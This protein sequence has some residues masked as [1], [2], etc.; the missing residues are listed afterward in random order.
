MTS[1]VAPSNEL[2]DLMC[3][4]AEDR[5]S[6]EG[7]ERLDELLCADPRNCQHYI[8]FMATITRLSWIGD[9]SI[10]DAAKPTDEGQSQASLTQQA[11]DC[12][13][14]T[15][16]SQSSAVES[17]SERSDVPPF[18]LTDTIHGA[19]GYSSGWPVAYGVATAICGLGLL[20]GALVHVSRPVPIAADLPTATKGQAAGRPNTEFVGR[21][22]GMI[23]CQW[24]DSQTEA[25]NGSSV[26]LGRKYVLSSGLMEI[27]Y[28]SG[29]NVILQG[30]VTY[31]VESASGGFLSAGRLTA[32]VEKGE[33]VLSTEYE[34][35]SRERSD[36]TENQKSEIRNQKSSLS[37]TH[38]PLFTIKTPTATVTDLGT[39]FGVEVDKQGGTTS[40]VFRGS[41]RVQ[42]V[43]V[44][45]ELEDGAEILRESQSARVECNGANHIA[46]LGPSATPTTFVRELPKRTIRV[47][48]LVDVVAGGNGFSG[49]RNRGIDPTTGQTT[50]VLAMEYLSGDRQYHRVQGLSFVDGVFIP[51]GHHSP[52][53]TDSI[54]AFAAFPPTTN[55]AIGGIWAVG[56]GTITIPPPFVRSGIAAKASESFVY[57]YEMDHLPSDVS[58]ADLD[59]NGH[60]DFKGSGDAAV[61]NGILTLT[62]A[63]ELSL[64]ATAIW[65]GKL[66]FAKG[67]TIEARVRVVSSSGFGPF[68]LLA[69]L[70]VNEHE[71]VSSWLNVGDNM[72]TWGPDG[73]LAKFACN[74]KDDYHVYRV[75]QEPGSDTCILWR[76]GVLLSNTLPSGL[77]SGGRDRM[78][79]GKLSGGGSGTALVDYVRFMPGVYA[80]VAQ[81]EPTDANRPA[82]IMTVP[83][84]LGGVDYAS[85]G[86]G[87]L[88]LHASKAIAFDLQAIRQANDNC[89]QMRFRSIVGNTETMSARGEAVSADIWVLV[90]GRPRFRRREINGFSGAMPINIPLGENDRFLTLAATDGGNGI[91]GDWIMFGDPRIELIM[92]AGFQRPAEVRT[93]DRRGP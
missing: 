81:A 4:L 36:T 57:K 9:D 2:V 48:D 25:F 30:P 18:L 59:D 68:Y 44:N 39:E 61:T 47:L 63:S 62:D 42:V 49:R 1:H 7:V 93:T 24:A 89:R 8:D 72:L 85:P 14:E 10:D 74:T 67:Y 13:C 86:H 28:D 15:H 17:S 40:H 79:F 88:F 20:V 58:H 75:A 83:T 76:D 66:S 56:E 64:D 16:I 65:P 45:G 50:N 3:D 90:D 78:G 55:R 32:K 77:D 37:T 52:V 87:G 6:P 84:E 29:A 46:M 91:H 82:N 31:E 54:H 60:Q 80:P 69:A 12:G 22:T 53:Q 5:L 41:V 43:A 38:S 34:V 92:P 21:I 73:D 26:P 33:T 11:I 51:D 27:T 70:P 23:D 71:D 19:A 35:R